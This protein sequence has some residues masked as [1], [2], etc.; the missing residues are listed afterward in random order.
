MKTKVL[1]SIFTFMFLFQQNTKAQFLRN[2][3]EKE[4]TKITEQFNT[5]T[6][7]RTIILDQISFLI[8]KNLK[9]N[10]TLNVV[11]IDKD[12]DSKSQQAMIWLQTGLLYYDIHEINVYSAGINVDSQPNFTLGNIEKYGFKV[13]NTNNEQPNSYNVKYGKK[14]WSVYPKHISSLKT[15]GENILKIYVEETT[16]EDDSE[17]KIELSFSNTTDIPINMLYIAEKLNNFINDQNLN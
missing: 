6:K 12:N 3:I 11:I 14:S 17:T 1:I 2:K 4:T 16:L 5:L 8:Y 7:E 15:E 13:K 9:D 10:E